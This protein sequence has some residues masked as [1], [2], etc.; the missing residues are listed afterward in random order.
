MT[1]PRPDSADGASVYDRAERWGPQRW[2]WEFLRRNKEFIS[3]CDE[4]RQN[5]TDAEKL[6]AA[7]RFGLKRFK[8]YRSSS[9]KGEAKPRHLRP[10][11]WRRPVG[12]PGAWKYR[13]TP[14]QLE[15]SIDVRAI[16]ASPD[17]AS[18]LLIRVPK[19][20][21]RKFREI[22]DQP[23]AHRLK[24]MRGGREQLILMLKI[25]DA[26]HVGKKHHEIARMLIATQVQ[27]DSD[28]EAAK[29]IRGLIDSARNHAKC[30]YRKF[31]NRTKK[32]FEKMLKELEAST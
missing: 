2:A 4:L 9:I 21:R 11:S 16:A 17:I 20:L 28:S 25:L 8:D 10:H 15:I 18:E 7:K 1:R 22:A 5:G 19:L 14:D 3:T 27:R 26:L 30:D 13:V 6:E 24:R 32:D 29:K 31:L 12:P 23:A